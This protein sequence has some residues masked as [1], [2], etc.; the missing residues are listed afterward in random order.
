MNQRAVTRT[1]LQIW[2]WLEIAVYAFHTPALNENYAYLSTNPVEK[3]YMV[4]LEFPEEKRSRR[5]KTK[6]EKEKS[7]SRDV[8]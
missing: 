4:T 1:N 6:R 7:E 5:K 2:L 8:L 3:Q